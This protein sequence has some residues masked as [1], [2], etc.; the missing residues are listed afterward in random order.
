MPEEY[1]FEVITYLS[2]SLLA[3]LLRVSFDK[4]V[5]FEFHWTWWQYFFD[6][7][8]ITDL[9]HHVYMDLGLFLVIDVHAR[10]LFFWT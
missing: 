8:I 6:A 1:N 2:G 10:I 3:D 4:F 5:L 9:W 7:Y